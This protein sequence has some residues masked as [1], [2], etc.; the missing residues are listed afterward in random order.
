MHRE[1]FILVRL[2]LLLPLVLLVT[3]VSHC[4]LA[5]NR[6]VTLV[7]SFHRYSKLNRIIK[8]LGTLKKTQEFRP[9]FTSTPSCSLRNLKENQQVKLSVQ[10]PSK[11]LNKTLHG[12]YQNNGK[13]QAR[14]IP[15]RMATA[16]MNCPP[17]RNQIVE[18]VMKVVSHEISDLRSKTNPSL[19]RKTG[20]EDLKKFNYRVSK[21]SQIL[22]LIFHETDR[23]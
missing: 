11:S 7:S 13:A 20:K 23:R 1:H 18:K 9:P 21:T 5:R 6:L 4:L 19:L 15:S 2:T 16:M 8:Y 22:R 12:T 3:A 14:G 10:Y 17:V